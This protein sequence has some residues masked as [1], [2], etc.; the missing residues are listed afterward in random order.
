MV[1]ELLD[2]MIG[3]LDPVFQA[4]SYIQLVKVDLAQM[5]EKTPLRN[6][7]FNKFFDI[8]EGVIQEN[9]ETTL[10]DFS[11]YGAFTAP[12]GGADVMDNL[13]GSL[14]DDQLLTLQSVNNKC[15]LTEASITMLDF[16]LGA[17][18]A[19]GGL[20][21]AMIRPIFALLSNVRTDMREFLD[22]T[23]HNTAIGGAALAGM[24]N[25]G[26]GSQM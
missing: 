24:G 19:A 4:I 8:L 13:I 22:R 17:I 5:S 6:S 9:S 15:R 16:N 14:A 3:Q 23:G 21:E 11:S 10:D 25:E 18:S 1:E 7:Q 20:I 26:F 2:E 12:N